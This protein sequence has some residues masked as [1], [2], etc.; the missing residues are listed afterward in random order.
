MKEISVRDLQHHM[1]EVFESILAGTTVV[2]KK[3][4]R[5]IARIVP[6]AQEQRPPEPW[7]DLAARLRS[8]YGSTM[9]SDGASD[10]I[11]GDRGP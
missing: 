6:F 11:Y 9:V 2:V 4:G 5:P 8:I 1:R 7:P 10:L 3:R